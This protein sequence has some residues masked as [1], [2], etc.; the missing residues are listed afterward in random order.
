ML[1]DETSVL[2]LGDLSILILLCKQYE[3]MNDSKKKRF[4]EQYNMTEREI[5][6]LFSKK[7]ELEK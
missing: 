5:Q 4:Y 2:S 3:T 1:R 6:G 7:A